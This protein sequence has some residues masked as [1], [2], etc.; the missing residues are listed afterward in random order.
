M[1]QS[2][3]ITIVEALVGLSILA[4]VLVFIVQT[5]TIFFASSGR[6]LDVTQATYLAEEGQEFVRYL[7]DEDWAQLSGLANDTDHYFDV[8]AANISITTT[9]EVVNDTFTRSFSLSS[10]ERD[11]NDDFVESGGTSD[12]GGRV[13]T[14]TI[15]WEGESISL[16]SLVTNIHSI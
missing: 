12:G 9:P 15:S 14:V 2:R 5:Q 16:T 11:V 3:G 8:D 4:V 6:A 1:K 13:V 7:R 10:L